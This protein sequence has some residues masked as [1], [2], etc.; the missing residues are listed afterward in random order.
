MIPLLTKLEILSRSPNKVQE[1]IL[2][3]RPV[4]IP[5]FF[6]CGLGFENIHSTYTIRCQKEKRLPTGVSEAFSA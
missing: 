3:A 5:C 4:T 6:A 2:Y 1:V